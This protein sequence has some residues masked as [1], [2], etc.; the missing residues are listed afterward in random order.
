[1][2]AY[3]FHVSLL[4]ECEIIL[5][6]TATLQTLISSLWPSLRWGLQVGRREFPSSSSPSCMS[7]AASLSRRVGNLSRANE[8]F[9]KKLVVLEH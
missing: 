4:L 8:D 7:P 1:M 6:Q 9:R 2:L 3:G 5:N